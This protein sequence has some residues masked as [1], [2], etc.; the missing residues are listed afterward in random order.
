MTF[1]AIGLL[2]PFSVLRMSNIL[3]KAAVL[4]EHKE[5][6]RIIGDV[7]LPKL[8]VGQ[9]LV[10]LAYSGVCHSQIMEID[11]LRGEDKYLPH[12]LVGLKDQV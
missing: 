7:K 9:V 2:D 4:Q 8:K 5:K 6:L 10:K 12:F 1:L 3:F 11:G